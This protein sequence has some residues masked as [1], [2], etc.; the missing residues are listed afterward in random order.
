MNPFFLSLAFKLSLS[1]F[2][3]ASVLLSSLGIYYIQKFADEIDRHLHLK[4]QIPGRLINEGALLRSQIRDREMLSHLVGEEI[5]VAV[6]TQSDGEILY[7]TDAEMEGLHLEEFPLNEQRPKTS[8]N[9]V[10]TAAYRRHNGNGYLHVSTPL[11]SEDGWSDNLYMTVSAANAT[12]EKNRSAIGFIAG[13]SLC[14][15]LITAVSALMVH[16][17]TVP[18]LSETLQCLKA[19]EQGD[20]RCASPVINRRMNWACW[21]GE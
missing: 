13:F 4:A 11:R 8:M 18:R 15:V 1:I 16:L 3:I 6:L 12:R 17:M 2:L 7:S 9:S 10:E 21:G 14:I 5:F 19:V 20:L